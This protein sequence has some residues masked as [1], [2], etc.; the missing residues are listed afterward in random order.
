MAEP[1]A[2][3]V[4]RA[5]RQATASE[6][7]QILQELGSEA[8]PLTVHTQIS[9]AANVA[10]LREALPVLDERA[11]VALL[12][13]SSLQVSGG[14][15][16]KDLVDLLTEHVDERWAELE[17][18][19][20]QVILL[21]GRFG[22]TVLTSVADRVRRS[23][24]SRGATEIAQAMA[25]LELAQ[26]KALE[27]AAAAAG[28]QQS[29]T[30][31]SAQEAAELYQELLQEYLQSLSPGQSPASLVFGPFTADDL[32]LLRE[33]KRYIAQHE[34]QTM[35]GEWRVLNERLAGLFG[36][37]RRVGMDPFTMLHEAQ[38]RA[39]RRRQPHVLFPGLRRG[40]PARWGGYIDD[41]DGKPDDGSH[42]WGGGRSH[43]E[44]HKAMRSWAEKRAAEKGLVLGADSAHLIP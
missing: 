6:R 19:L 44:M 9:I 28:E 35:R 39:E 3:A 10:S 2:A 27:Q 30:E 42:H 25:L 13:D 24:R 38:I 11:A 40:E 5:L 32:L 1:T 26:A 37:C 34:P 17:P 4:I 33:C 7:S 12:A 43:E 23:R 21:C 14:F 20:G 8:A 22:R 36:R 29:N 18:L 16:K 15:T 31:A 41:V